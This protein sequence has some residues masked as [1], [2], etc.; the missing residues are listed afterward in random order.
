MQLTN[1]GELVGGRTSQLIRSVE[2]R[3]GTALLAVVALAASAS[4][5]RA[6]DAAWQPSPGH[7]QVPIWPN[8]VP[9]ARPV[10][11]PE[12][13][14]TV[15]DGA[16]SKRLVA[17]RPWVYVARVSQP[18]MTV[19]LYPTVDGADKESCRPDFAVA[20]YPGHL[21]AGRRLELNPDV[22]VTR[23]T[24]PTFL[25]HAEDDAVDDVNHSLVYYAALKKVGVPVEM[26]L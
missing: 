19:F 21:W 18:T 13:S 17:G 16:G 22:P 15:V 4:G 23:E 20:L 5:L 6:E 25:L 10:E 9:D 8:A 14:G 1:R 3:V 11:G 2:R 7:T 24:P 26:H 12:E